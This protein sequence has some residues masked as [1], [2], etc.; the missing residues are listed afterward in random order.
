MRY[1]V[2]KHGNYRSH[3]EEMIRDAAVC[4]ECGEFNPDMLQC[5]FEYTFKK[6][7]IYKREY[8]SGRFL[9][10]TCKCIFESDRVCIGKER[11]RRTKEDGSTD[12]TVLSDLLIALASMFAIAIGIVMIMRSCYGDDNDNKL[13]GVCGFVI[14]L[15]GIIRF[16]CTE[17]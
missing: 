11:S 1:R 3:A 17:D 8:I 2:I 7:L 16:L 14:A 12:R 10:K 4:P 15:V 6:N 5:E 9:C 13:L